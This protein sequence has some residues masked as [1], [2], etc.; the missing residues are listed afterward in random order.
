MINCLKKIDDLAEIDLG[1]VI[2]KFQGEIPVFT[3]IVIENFFDESKNRNAVSAAFIEKNENLLRLVKI[4]CIKVEDYKSYF[5]LLP[6]EIE[7]DTQNA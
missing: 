2:V 3:L 7:D 4:S 5:I 6:T 1:T